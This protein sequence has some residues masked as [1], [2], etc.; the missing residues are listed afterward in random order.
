MVATNMDISRSTATGADV[1]LAVTLNDDTE[2]N[3][4]GLRRANNE[5]ITVVISLEIPDGSGGFHLIRP[6]NQTASTA[7][8]FVITDV[9]RLPSGS[10]VRIQTT[11]VTTGL[12]EA[13]II[14]DSRQPV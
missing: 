4:M 10:V 5:A 2:V 14:T 8:D 1:N 11:G 3:L 13:V 7:L 9:F 12:V 6:I